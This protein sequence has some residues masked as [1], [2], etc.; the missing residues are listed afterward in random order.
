MTFIVFQKLKINEQENKMQS[1]HPLRKLVYTMY[2]FIA[3]F[4][5]T[6][7]HLSAEETNTNKHTHTHTQKFFIWNNYPNG[8]IRAAMWMST[9]QLHI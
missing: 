6:L 5:S 1:R 2:A 7:V 3:S 8:V 4:K 9:C